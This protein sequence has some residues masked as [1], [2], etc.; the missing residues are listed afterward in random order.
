MKRSSL[1]LFSFLLL[2]LITSC[3]K[4]VTDSVATPPKLGPVPSTDTLRTDHGGEEA[5]I[6][7]VEVEPEIEDIVIEL[8]ASLQKT[9]CYGTCPSFEV[10]YYSDGRIS[11]HGKLHAK[12]MGIYE[13]WG[14]ENFK[15][16]LEL[17]A[18]KYNYFDF[19]EEYPT[20]GREIADLPSTITSL[21][22]DGRKRQV[23]N[24]YESPLPL[25]EFE[26]ELEALFDQ[27]NWT[28]IKSN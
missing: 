9:A 8:V 27:Q 17:L 20:N 22:I 16:S 11:Y 15:T 21:S 6:E 10:K 19:E 1:F 7:I 18:R 23:T 13:A 5:E 28:L 12:R 24:N 3:N 25:R 4:K 14:D 2:A 26:K